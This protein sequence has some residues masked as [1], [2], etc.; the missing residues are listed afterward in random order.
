MKPI[1]KNIF[2]FLG[3]VFLIY[4]IYTFIQSENL[5][6]KY[7]KNISK[8][9]VGMSL[10]E[11]RHIVGDLEYQYWTQD[12]KSGEIIVSKKNNGEL[13]YALEYDMVFGGSDNPKIYFD[14]NTLI[15]TEV[16]NGE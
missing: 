6:G 16:L 12:N 13:V 2:V 11:A 7:W 10:D 4:E 15:V 8:V 9:K 1:I 3:V 5:T 14:P